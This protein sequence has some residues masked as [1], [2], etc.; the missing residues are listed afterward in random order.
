MPDFHDDDSRAEEASRRWRGDETDADLTWGVV[1]SGDS[2]FDTARTITDLPGGRVDVLELGPGY[3]RLLRWLLAGDRVESYTGVDLSPARVDRLGQTFPD[4]RCSFRVQD[5]STLDLDGRFDLFVC[6]S[7]FEHLYPGMDA[8]LRRIRDHL[9]PGGL[10]IFDLLQSDDDLTLE[11]AN[12]A[13]PQSGF[14]RVYSLAE[15]RKILEAAGLELIGWRSYVLPLGDRPLILDRAKSG[16]LIRNQ[17]G[18]VLIGD[19]RV[20]VE[21]AL[22]CCRRTGS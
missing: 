17:G 21:R 12:L 4:P 22:F 11:W 2:F 15:I 13:S 5:A 14:V 16:G 18:W 10:A 8:A 1:I 19:T 6:S 20:G 9:R 3:G 7:T